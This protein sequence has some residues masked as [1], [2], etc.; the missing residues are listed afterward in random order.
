M[1]VEVERLFREGEVKEKK[2]F[3]MAGHL[4]GIVTFGATAEE[5]G[6]VLMSYLAKA[7]ALDNLS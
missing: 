1:S 7:V 3:S 2:I 5:A 4:D 6:G